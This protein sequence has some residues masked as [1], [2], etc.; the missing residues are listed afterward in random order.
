MWCV[1]FFPPN[2]EFRL[3][4]CS[5]RATS[6]MLTCASLVAY[7]AAT[8]S[9]S[10]ISSSVGPGEMDSPSKA[11]TTKA[12]EAE[13][14]SVAELD[15]ASAATDGGR[16]VAAAAAA[17]PGVTDR[18]EASVALRLAALSSVD[19][20]SF[21]GGP[22]LGRAVPSSSPS[23]SATSGWSA[24]ATAAVAT[25]TASLAPSCEVSICFVIGGAEMSASLPLDWSG[26]VAWFASDT[27]S[28]VWELSLLSPFSPSGA[29]LV[30][31]ATTFFFLDEGR[32]FAD[33]FD[34]GWAGVG[35]GV[36]FAPTSGSPSSAVSSFG[37]L[38]CF[39]GLGAPNIPKKSSV[40]PAALGEPLPLRA[41]VVAD[42][43][44]LVFFFSAEAAE[45]FAFAWTA[46]TAAFDLFSS[47]SSCFDFPDEE[48]RMAPGSSL[49][50][51][52]A[53]TLATAPW[54]A[55]SKSRFFRS[56]NQLMLC[57]ECLATQSR[58][59]PPTRLS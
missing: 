30:V 55:F 8:A 17:V 42:E 7:D 4:S 39:V 19:T 46:S 34:V 54:N 53:S 45:S 24:T 38:P 13:E 51:N 22:G 25:A 41:S 1:S 36:C 44:A 33:R 58:S 35:V 18:A 11:G 10:E 21:S 59:P 9:R 50:S 29:P 26:G 56:G 20:G 12:A 28:S 15:V 40:L 37:G 49:M 52:A 3:T 47:R 14:V 43:E 6:T 2:S 48:E 57:V 5:S 27:M 32:F 23:S 16:D 31:T